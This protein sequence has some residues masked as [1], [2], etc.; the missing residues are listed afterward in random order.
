MSLAVFLKDRRLAIIIQLI[1]LAASCA[2][3]AIVSRNSA[4][5]ILVGVVMLAA[6]SVALTVEYLPR[7]LYYRELV[8]T[9]ES[10]DHK[11]LMAEVVA[12][13]S[14]EEGRFTHDLLQTANKAMLEEIAQYR[15]RE[16]DYREYIELWVHE[17]KAPIASA[18]LV[19]KNNPAP[20]TDGMLSEFERVE[21]LVAQ[22][23]FYARSNSVARDFLVRETTL[24]AVVNPAIRRHARAFIER[25]I[26]LE[27]ENLELRVFTDAKW[28]SFVVQQVL[29]NAVAYTSDAD[30]RIR[31]EGRQAEQSVVLT[32]EDNGCGIP[33][34][35]LPR[36][37]D[38]GFT[39]SNGRQRNVASTGLGLYLVRKLADRIGLGVS[40]DSVVGQGTTVTIVFPVLS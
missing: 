37:W 8:Q 18:K 39:G 28:A 20:A 34:S 27:V 16:T 38:K 15:E 12:P 36:V 4:I 6:I 31:V 21:D 26:V 33:A 3:V 1:A 19:A 24:Q 22:T 13:P 23:L 32:I 2:A 25:R 40:I 5:V 29:A 30:A 35:E 11:N 10:L 17:I 14:F 7:R 9:V